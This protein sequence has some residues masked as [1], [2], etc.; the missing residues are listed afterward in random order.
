M[1]VENVP[2]SLI[3]SGIY[4]SDDIEIIRNAYEQVLCRRDGC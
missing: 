4:H 1:V 2:E 3:R